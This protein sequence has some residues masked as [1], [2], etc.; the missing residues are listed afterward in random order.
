MDPKPASASVTSMNELVLPSDSNALGTAFGGRVLQWIDICAAIAAQRHCRSRVV[1]ASMDAVHFHAPIRVGMVASLEARVQATFTRSLELSVKVHSE[2]P[3]SGE[4]R[5]C[6][7]ALL[8]FT[9]L[10]ERFEPTE[11]PPLRLD[12]ED[13]RSRQTA[14]E[15]RRAARL[16]HRVESLDA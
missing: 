1:T 7:S 9:A 11:V 13:D 10:N 14:A 16:R 12:T 5:H 6:C 4:R 15:A 3:V 8:T 2:N